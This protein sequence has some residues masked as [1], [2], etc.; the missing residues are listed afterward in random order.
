MSDIF[1]ADCIYDPTADA[2]SINKKIDYKQEFCVELNQDV[3]MDFDKNGSPISLEILHVSEI[4]KTTKVNLMKIISVVLEIKITKDT[5]NVDANFVIDVRNN[6]QSKSTSA[7][8]IN[9]YDIPVMEAKLA[10]A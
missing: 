1:E 8:T 6:K 3:I 9:N 2:L 4:L 10:T 5:I 7:N